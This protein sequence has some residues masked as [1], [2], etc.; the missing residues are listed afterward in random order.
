MVFHWVDVTQ[1]HAC[2]CDH[3]LLTNYVNV[4]VNLYSASSQKAPLMRS[5]CRVLIK[6]TL[7]VW[8]LRSL[9][10]LIDLRPTN[11]KNSHRKHVR[12]IWTSF[13][14]QLK[15]QITCLRPAVSPSATF[16]FLRLCLKPV[17]NSFSKSLF[18]VLFLL[19]PCNV[20]STACLA[21]V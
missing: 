6:K 18:Q 8:A 17:H 15:P 7:C 11:P 12:Q 20:H 3:Q 4:N 2:E 1:A 14:S 5:M 19:W 13:I 21:I 16:I 9:H 10:G